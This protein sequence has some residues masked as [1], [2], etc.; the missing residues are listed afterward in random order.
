TARTEDW[1]F[2]KTTLFYFLSLPHIQAAGDESAWAA[3]SAGKPPTT[4]AAASS[5]SA[6]PPKDTTW[7]L[8]S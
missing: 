6:S 3:K 1:H 7:A 8:P 5:K 2:L 4:P